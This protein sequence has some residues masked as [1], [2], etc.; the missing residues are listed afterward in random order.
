M[1]RTAKRTMTRT[2]TRA[3]RLATALGA[4]LVATGLS[5]LCRAEGPTAL[6]CGAASESA[7]VLQ[8][9]GQLRAARAQLFVCAAASCPDDLRTECLRRGGELDVAMPTIVFGAADASG[10]EVVPVAVKMDGEPLTQRLDGTALSIDPGRH[11]FSFEA[12]GQPGVM[13]QLLILEG[14]KYRRE[15]VTLEPIVVLPAGEGAPR[16]RAVKTASLVLGG[17]GVAAV[18][19]GLG[20]GLVAISRRDDA[21]EA[22]PSACATDAD[23]ERWNR[24][25]AAGDVS[26][27]AFAVGGVALASGLVLWLVARHDAE[28][29]AGAQLAFGPGGV[30]LRGQW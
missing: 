3:T 26:T 25:R 14:E 1:K 4:C 9:R 28:R 11:T 6:D 16:R 18:A 27:V 22:C 30:T 23:V 5:P 15:H 12:P 20:Y 19:V 21:V 8:T 7:R 29:L 17:L 2:T 10:R 24:A 13:K